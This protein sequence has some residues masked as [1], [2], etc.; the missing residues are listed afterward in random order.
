M[1][2]A[3]PAFAQSIFDYNDAVFLPYCSFNIN[4]L[5]RFDA[6]KF[7]LQANGK[8]YTNFY[9]K[10]AEVVEILYRINKSGKWKDESGKNV[11]QYCIHIMTNIKKS[12]YN[13]GVFPRPFYK[14]AIVLQDGWVSSMD[15]P[16]IMVA[17]QM[18]YELT[19]DVQ[20]KSFIEDLKK[21]VLKDINDGGFSLYAPFYISNGIWPLEYA[22]KGLNEKQAMFV[23]NGSL[24]GYLGIKIIAELEN[25]K[26]LRDYLKKVDI[27]YEKMFS[28]FAYRSYTWTKYMLYPPKVIPVHYL[29]FEYELFA[30]LSCLSDNPL[31]KKE[32][33]YRKMCLQNALTLQFKK[34]DDKVN[35][36]LHRACR[37]HPYQIDSYGSKIKFFDKN[38][39]EIK[40]FEN[41]YKPVFNGDI[42]NFKKGEF[43]HG[44]VPP[45][46]VSY[47]YIRSDNNCVYFTEKINLRRDNIGISGIKVYDCKH[48]ANNDAQFYNGGKVLI[49]KSLS[50]YKDARIY[51]I[52]ASPEILDDEYYYGIEVENKSKENLSCGLLLYDTENCGVDR[53]WMPLKPG[54]NLVLF[55]ILGFVEI[56]KLKNIKRIDLRIYTEGIKNDIV[57][58]MGKLL[59]FKDL[60][61][62]RKYRL[63]S[64]YEINPQA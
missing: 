12:F 18:L 13:H 24:V 44:V 31:F 48:M 36:I 23:L 46:A 20:W 27:A 1:V 5:K 34:I 6:H 39:L 33:N 63:K 26:N 14:T 53:Y 32:L 7:G 10:S 47:A 17:S 61:E 3:K 58:R 54:K 52:L 19:K 2:F 40:S 16:T 30:A 21:Y 50:A 29:M 8:D 43:L 56:D 49:K 64:D 9:I 41:N 4:D 28:D 37:P 57:L 11:L 42:N 35:F 15:A 62:L 45:N 55:N 22:E 60:F 25:D 51:Y 38:N 59:R